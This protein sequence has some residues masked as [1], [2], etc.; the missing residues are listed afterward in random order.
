MKLLFKFLLM[1]KHTGL[2]LKPPIFN[3]CSKAPKPLNSLAL[4][5]KLN[6]LSIRI[7]SQI[8]SHNFLTEFG[9]IFNQKSPHISFHYVSCLIRK[10]NYFQKGRSETIWQTGLRIVQL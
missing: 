8:K 6:H 2:I 7:L 10:F 9:N 4:D 1:K 3:V 5:F